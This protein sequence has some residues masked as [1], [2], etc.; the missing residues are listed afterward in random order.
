MLHD[1]SSS[2]TNGASL[3]RREILR[4]GG[5]GL[6][7]LLLGVRCRYA[8]AAVGR[9]GRIEGTV[10][11]G[12]K[13]PRPAR[14]K[15]SGDCAYCRPFDLRAE[16]L[17]Q[18][19]GGGLRNA[20][21]VLEGVAGG[22]PIPATTPVLAEHRCT[23]VPHV[24]ALCAGQKLLLHNQD[25]VLN[26]F[27]AVEVASGSTLFNIGTPNKDQKVLRRIPRPGVVKMLCDVHPWELGYV[28]AFAHPYH[29]VSDASGAFLLDE[30]PAGRYQLA[31]WHEK[32]GGRRQLVEVRAGETLRLT[33][34]YPA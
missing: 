5:A 1:G 34:H 8:E 24:L 3:G 23:F 21:V 31:L 32:L 17:L 2:G 16:E 14:L 4:A 18:G 7:L 11:Y 27:H 30:V 13:A 19:A 26:T 12:G 33:L 20:V 25:P 10:R 22:K 15:L 28:L 6:G 9:A 29:T